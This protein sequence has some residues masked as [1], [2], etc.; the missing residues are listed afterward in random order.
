M[1]EQLRKELEVDEGCV[2]S[3]YLDHLGYKTVGIGHLCRKGDPE[4]NME[5]G[6][7]VSEERV[8]ELFD[9][10]IAQTIEDCYKLIPDWDMLPEEIQLICANMC[11]NLGIN[12]LGRF[13]KFFA[14]VENRDWATAADEMEDSKWHRQDV[15]K[16]SGRLIVRMRKKAEK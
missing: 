4:R 16:R 3:I 11:F 8:K 15:P 14:A 13:E 10:D 5:V 12:R 9:R 2:Y 1:I 7:P 6:T